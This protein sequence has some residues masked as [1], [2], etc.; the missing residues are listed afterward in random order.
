MN[1]DAHATK[2]RERERGGKWEEGQNDIYYITA[3]RDQKGRRRGTH[4]VQA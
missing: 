2:E 3:K 1:T 4:I